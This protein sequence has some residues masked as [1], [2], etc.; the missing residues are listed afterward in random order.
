MRGWVVF[1]VS[2]PESWRSLRVSSYC[3]TKTWR[4]LPLTSAVR[5]ASGRVV[6]PSSGTLSKVLRMCSVRLALS[7]FEC[8]AA[9]HLPYHQFLEFLSVTVC[10]RARL[11]LCTHFVIFQLV[12]SC[13]AC[14]FFASGMVLA[15]TVPA[16]L[17]GPD[18][19]TCGTRP[20]CSCRR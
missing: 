10:V 18:E 1:P 11:R 9:L 20:G 7:P 4:E 15:S 5:A 3:I 16:A 12:C 14:W 8:K 6:P 17:P 19:R 2:A 13:R